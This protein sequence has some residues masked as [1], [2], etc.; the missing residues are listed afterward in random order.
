[1]YIKNVLAGVAVSNHEKSVEW[2]SALIGR[3]PD[4]EPMRGLAEWVFEGGGWLQLFS[5]D[6]RAGN[7]SV[8]F[9]DADIFARAQMLEKIDV[10]I[11]DQ[12]QSGTVNTITAHDPDG[13][14]IVFA[15]GKD[16]AHRS[17]I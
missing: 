9:A 15:E 8:T 5:D 4:A 3:R 13:N 10:K 16:F 2:Y 6:K 17:T 14:Q 7:S 11:D 1:M 12:S